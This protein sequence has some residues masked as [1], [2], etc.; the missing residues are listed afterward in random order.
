M[1][2]SRKLSSWL[3][4]LFIGELSLRRLLR[5]IVLIPVVTVVGLMSYGYMFSDRIIFQPPSPGY[6]DSEE[7]IKLTTSD[8][9][10]ISAI[11]LPN[12]NATQ[13][14]LFSH[15]NAEDLGTVGFKLRQ[16]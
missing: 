8:G 4:Y 7:I 6:K 9:V 13:T 5:S 15:G 10:R 3:H 14:I 16:L 2:V 1:S 11:Y 12:E